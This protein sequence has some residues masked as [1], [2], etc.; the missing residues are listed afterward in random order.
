M[1]RE[2]NAVV[3]TLYCDEV[4][5]Q[6]MHDDILGGPPEYWDYIGILVVPASTQ[7]ALVSRL[8]NAR[9]LN[10]DNKEW[11]GCKS[12][13]QWHDDNN[14]EVHYS[15]LDDTR[16][17]KIAC[18]WVDLLLEN[19]TRGWGLMYFYI[20]G[21]NRS[22]LDLERF[23]PANQRSRDVTIYNRFFRTAVQKSTKS[24][25]HRFR[26][27]IVD[28]IYHDVAPGQ[29]HQFLPWH[30]IWKLGSE[31]DKLTF[32]CREISFINSD[33]RDTEGDPVH[34]HLIQFI[35]LLLG[36][37]CNIL[38]YRAKS[39]NKLGIALRAKPLLGDRLL[40]RPNN[41]NSRYHYFGRQQ[42]EFFPRESLSRDDA[43]SIIYEM[44]RLDNFY[45]ARELRIER[46]YQP[47]LPFIAGQDS[48]IPGT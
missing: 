31:D 34:S 43:D 19:A 10:P 6:P 38:H 28:H 45:S 32:L 20:L 30:A 7:E 41:K 2:G 24:F 48:V 11:D 16:R 26:H 3:L 37:T 29:H 40:K 18:S 44:R 13:C 46:H 22:K 33:H 47:V 17:Y 21:L 27:I 9:C 8:L 15:E 36:C 4:I 42:I 1:Q 25:F 5:K 23:G 14:T 35:D 12:R 39:A